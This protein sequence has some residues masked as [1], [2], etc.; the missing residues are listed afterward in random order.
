MLVREI[1]GRLE[2]VHTAGAREATPEE[3]ALIEARHDKRYKQNEINRLKQELFRSDYQALKYAEGH[4]SEAEYAGI[5]AQRQAWRD[6]INELEAELKEE[7][8][9]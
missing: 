8:R 5:K 9:V 4:V 3:I 1:N 7:E 6:R 2:Q